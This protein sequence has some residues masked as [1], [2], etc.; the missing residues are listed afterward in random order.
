M[1]VIMKI[2]N[3]K[4]NNDIPDYI[5]TSLSHISM[6]IAFFPSNSAFWLPHGRFNHIV[7]G[8]P[9]VVRL[10]DSSM[11]GLAGAQSAVALR[12]LLQWGG[13][14]L[15]TSPALSCSLCRFFWNETNLPLSKRA[16]N[17]KDKHKQNTWQA[18][19]SMITTGMQRESRCVLTMNVSFLRWTLLNLHLKLF[20]YMCLCSVSGPLCVCVEHFFLTFHAAD[21]CVL[22]HV[23]DVYSFDSIALHMDGLNQIPQSQWRVMFNGAEGTPQRLFRKEDSLV[24]RRWLHVKTLLIPVETT[25]KSSFWESKQSHFQH[26]VTRRN[27]MNAANGVETTYSRAVFFLFHILSCLD[28]ER[29]PAR[30]ECARIKATLKINPLWLIYFLNCQTNLK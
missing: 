2:M 26:L 5:Q 6:V 19:N 24:L 29:F 17:S 22:D 8:K 11:L 3:K 28:V 21:V 20:Y 23:P 12:G 25:E 9:S 16:F 7:Y 14:C 15:P 13:H 27:H 10:C 30:L 18:K 1:T 4:S